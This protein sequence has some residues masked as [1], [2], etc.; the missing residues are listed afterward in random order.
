MG[1]L[2]EMKGLG[3]RFLRVSP[4]TDHTYTG[5]DSQKGLF[6]LTITKVIEG[7]V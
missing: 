5:I 7:T 4:S 6:S 1:H 3:I 2:L